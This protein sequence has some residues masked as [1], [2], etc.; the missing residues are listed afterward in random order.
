[1]KRL[2]RLVRRRSR[3]FRPRVPFALVVRGS[4]L[5]IALIFMKLMQ[6][7][8]RQPNVVFCT[9]AL[10]VMVDMHSTATVV[11][12]KGTPLA[13][14][15]LLHLGPPVLIRGVA[16]VEDLYGRSRVVPLLLVRCGLR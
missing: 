15:G 14:P 16:V 5:G 6:F 2:G 9:N 7:V 13:V 10:S 1:M 3:M 11:R 4:R 12:L 8:I